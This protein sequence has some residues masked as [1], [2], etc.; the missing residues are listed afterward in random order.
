[1]DP[2]ST[3]DEV[4]TWPVGAQLDLVFRLWDEIVASGEA[5]EPNMELLQ[6]LERRSAAYDADPTNVRTWDQLLEKL[7]MPR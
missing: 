6:E 7:K 5:P 4:R 2:S 3:L 1:M